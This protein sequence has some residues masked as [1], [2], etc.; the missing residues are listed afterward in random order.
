[1]ES[2]PS[3]SDQYQLRSRRPS[4]E[5]FRSSGSSYDNLNIAS[6]NSLKKR[7]YYFKPQIGPIYRP[8]LINSD[9]LG[10]NFAYSVV[11]SPTIH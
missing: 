11:E 8:D 2:S 10:G 6:E 9:R 4:G 5:R 1:M 7:Q 3:G